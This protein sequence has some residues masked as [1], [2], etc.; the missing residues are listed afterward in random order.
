MAI[1]AGALAA[2][3]PP[4][5]MPPMPVDPELAASLQALAAKDLR[6]A[7]VAYRLQTGGRAHCP[8]HTRLS[9]LVV[10]DASQYRADLRPAVAQLFGLT[11]LPTVTA[12]VPD[13]AG[14]GAGIQV[15][16][17]ILLMNGQRLAD[18]LPGVTKRS[19]DGSRFSALLDRLDTAFAA[20]PVTLEL[21]RDGQPL[22]VTVNGADACRSAVQLDLS[23]ARNASADGRIVSVSQGVL[24]FTRDD[25]ELAFVIGHELSHNILGHRDFLDTAHVSDGVLRGIGRNGARIRD[26]E[27]QADYFGVY[28]TAWAGYDPHAA[29][30]FWKR[31][32]HADP[33]GGLFSDGTHPGNGARVRDLERAADE[34]D[35][36]RAAGQPLDPHYQRKR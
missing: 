29:A 27:R 22:T 31:M 30:R 2:A 21:R 3:A 10:Q 15:G 25:D 1:T 35:A 12:V 26:T 17:G 4:P 33:L 18:E 24:D 34:I 20:G 6:V 11:D 23:G 32:A 36:K 16:D 13:S 7:T 9:G 28:L 14:A 19:A 8:R 5:P